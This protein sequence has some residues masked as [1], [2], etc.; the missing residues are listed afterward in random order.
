MFKCANVNLD[1]GEIYRLDSTS[2]C[3]SDVV[4]HGMRVKQP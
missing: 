4:F 1:L 2:L 3:I